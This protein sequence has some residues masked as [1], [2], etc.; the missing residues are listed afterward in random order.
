MKFIKLFVLDATYQLISR[1]TNLYENPNIINSPIIV[2][3][4]N[5]RVINLMR[6]LLIDIDNR[7]YSYFVDISLDGVTYERLIDC[8]RNY[9]RSWQNLY[10]SPQPFK[11]IKLVGTQAIGITKKRLFCS[12][13]SNMRVYGDSFDVIGLQAMYVPKANV[14]IFDG[15]I[16]PSFNI[17]K[18]KNGFGVIVIEGVGGNNM[19]NDNLEDFTC[20]GQKGHILLLFNQPY[21]ISSLRM[22]LGNNK[23]NAEKYSFFIETSMDK[24]IWKIAVDKRND[25][26]SGWQEFKFESRPTNFIKITGTQTGNVCTYLIENCN[27]E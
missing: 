23:I 21:H 16:K 11:F 8:T 17:A 7:S 27:R 26:L 24:T 10:F 2:D 13:Y 9:C 15:F 18:S 5:V 12:Q 14:E 25:L 6:I 4:G 1:P 19:L 3:L 20:H 22:L